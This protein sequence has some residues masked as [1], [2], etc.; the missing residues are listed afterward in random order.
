VL[1]LIDVC[2]LNDGFQ[3]VV[4]TINFNAVHGFHLLFVYL[5]HKINI[6][7]ALLLD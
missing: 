7:L 3:H 5:E 2:G 1:S 4:I 6:I